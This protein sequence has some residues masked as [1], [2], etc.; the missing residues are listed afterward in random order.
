MNIEDKEIEI[1]ESKLP[2]LVIVGGGFAGIELVKKIDPRHYQ[3]IMVDR[4]N[5]HTFQPLLYQVAT[6]GLEPDSIAQPLRKVFDDKRNFYFR[7]ANVD[8]IEPY[9]NK[10]YTDIGWIKYDILVVAIGTRTNYFGNDDLR[11]ATLPMKQVP[12]SLDIRSHML[13]SLEAAL[14]EPNPEKRNALMSFVIVGGGPT[15]VELAGALSELKKHV[16]PQDYPELNINAMKI[17]LVEGLGR[18]LNGMSDFAGRK[19]L[20][21]LQDFGVEVILNNLVSSVEGDKVTL[22]DNRVIYADNVLWAAGVT[23]NLFNGFNDSMIARGS[24]LIVNEFNLVK[25][26]NN[27]YAIGDIAYMESDDDFPKG[28][29]QLAPVAIQQGEALGRNLNRLAENKPM[30]PF[31]YFNK[32]VMATIGR[33]RA[34]VDLPFKNISYGG[35]FAWLTWMFI[36]LLYL[37]GFRS[38]FVTFFNWIYNYFTYDRGTRL[39]VRP[40]IKMRKQQPQEAEVDAVKQ[41]KENSYA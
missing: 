28:H 6:A 12:H 11:E 19:S 38:K 31:D 13:Q 30:K 26:L 23:G 14:L 34:V 7:M 1:P 32:G 35:F 41:T 25:G 8:R 29:P 9:E 16:L 36:H 18:L 21:Y 39:I 5:Y 27:V 2:K 4:H 22:K 10:L 17:Y 24:R 40:Y 33:N 37:V 3:I 20:Q 15:G